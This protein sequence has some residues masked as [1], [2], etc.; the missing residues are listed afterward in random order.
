MAKKK[1]T[2]SPVIDITGLNRGATKR[3]KLEH[4]MGEPKELHKAETF[5]GYICKECWVVHA[6]K[7][8]ETIDGEMKLEFQEEKLKKKQITPSEAELEK[9]IKEADKKDKKK[10]K[11]VDGEQTNLF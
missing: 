4:C 5:E 6:Y 9:L 8:Q 10:I 2:K 11:K 3:C 1:E 7:P